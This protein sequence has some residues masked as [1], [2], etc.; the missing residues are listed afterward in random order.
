MVIQHIQ[1]VAFEK[2]QSHN[3]EQKK[4][5]QQ[6]INGLEI[7]GAYK[8][9]IVTQLVPYTKFWEAEDYHQDYYRLNP[10]NPYI[11]S[12]ARP[13]VKKFEDAFRRKLKNQ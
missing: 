13:K 4:L 7:A 1:A 11:E 2:Q 6:Y 5:A 12:V 8:N 10:T 9:R 3:Q